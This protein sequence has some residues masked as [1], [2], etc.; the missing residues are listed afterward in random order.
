MG[1]DFHINLNIKTAGGFESYGKFFIGSN[2]NA[3]EKIFSKLNGTKEVN[4]KSIL[5]VEFVE[6]DRNLPL[7]IDV[8]SCTLEE[9][10]KNIKIIT[11]EVFKLLNLENV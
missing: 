8:I 5:I 9:L 11:K 6:T 1:T 2:R 4:S 7:N 10:T 3:A